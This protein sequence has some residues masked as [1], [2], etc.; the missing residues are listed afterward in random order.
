MRGREAIIL[1]SNFPRK[2]KKI[3]SKVPSTNKVDIQK[4]FFKYQ[5][6]PV[7]RYYENENL[8]IRKKSITKTK[9]NM[10]W[11]KIN[12]KNLQYILSVLLKDNRCKRRNTKFLIRKTEYNSS[13]Q[14]SLRGQCIL[15]PKIR[16][17][18]FIKECQGLH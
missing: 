9:P 14:V 1:C 11:H 12:L 2:S 3:K 18:Y 13:L 7:W 16:M 6:N 17:G 15:P 4:G 8:I 5:Q 10:L